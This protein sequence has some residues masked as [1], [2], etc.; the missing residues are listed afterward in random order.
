MQIVFLP[1]TKNKIFEIQ[2]MLPD[3]KILSLEDIGCYEDIP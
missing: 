2:S 1:A 3:T